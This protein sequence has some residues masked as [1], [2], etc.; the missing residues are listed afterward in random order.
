MRRAVVRHQQYRCARRIRDDAA[1][2]N[3]SWG[4]TN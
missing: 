4:T 2:R 1:M 3:A